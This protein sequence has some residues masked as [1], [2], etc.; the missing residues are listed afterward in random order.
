M[1]FILF[2][3][4]C[5]FDDEKNETIIYGQY[6]EKINEINIDYLQYEVVF[7]ENKP[8]FYIKIQGKISYLENIQFHWDNKVITR[9]LFTAKDPQAKGKFSYSFKK[10]E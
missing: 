7:C 3:K 10:G 8:D 9:V 2:D 4:V 6:K 5:L 1:T